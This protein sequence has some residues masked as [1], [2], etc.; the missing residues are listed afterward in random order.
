LKDRLAYGVIECAEKH[1]H[2]KPDQSIVEASSGNPGIGL[3]MICASKG[4]PL[5]CVMSEFFSVERR[6]AMPFFGAKVILTNPA[7]K[8]TGMVIKAKELA[9]KHGG[10]F[11]NQFDNEVNAWIH[12]QTTTG[13]EIIDAFA[14]DTKKLDHFEIAY[15]T[16]GSSLGMGRVLRRESRQQR[17]QADRQSSRSP[18]LKHTPGKD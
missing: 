6:K 2:L 17:K 9:D 18:R 14:A 10:F 7:H 4:Y 8:A 11:P 15:G 5:V 1:G 3:A 16:W 13:P 12:E